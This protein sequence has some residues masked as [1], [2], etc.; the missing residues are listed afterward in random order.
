[1]SAGNHG[2]CPH[3][4]PMIGSSPYYI[5]CISHREATRNHYSFPYSN[6]FHQGHGPTPGQSTM[7]ISAQNQQ[8][9]AVVQEDDW[10]PYSNPVPS[11]EGASFGREYGEV[12]D[13]PPYQS[14]FIAPALIHQSTTNEVTISSDAKY[15]DVTFYDTPRQSFDQEF[16]VEHHGLED[17]ST[18]IENNQGDAAP[19]PT[20]PQGSTQ[21]SEN[22]PIGPS[23]I[24]RD[25]QLKSQYIVDHQ[26]RRNGCVYYQVRFP[27]MFFTA[28][29]ICMYPEALEAYHQRLPPEQLAKLL[30]VGKP[31]KKINTNRNSSA[32]TTN[33][34]PTSDEI[35]SPI[36]ISPFTPAG[37]DE[38]SPVRLPKSRRRRAPRSQ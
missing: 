7:Y 5:P 35:G 2:L 8:V 24:H 6:A 28:T 18:T 37:S 25:G 12:E 3:H 20:M 23:T 17:L 22:S 26:V 27:D 29:E 36:T 9:E 30:T 21:G 11:F 4:Q 19:S 15:S 14:P 10:R 13:Q 1:M 31:K 38:E 34:V 16:A 32:R 33:V